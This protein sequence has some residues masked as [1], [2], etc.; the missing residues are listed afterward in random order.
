MPLELIQTAIQHAPKDDLKQK[1]LILSTDDENPPNKTITIEDVYIK[2]YAKE[3]QDARTI[4][5]PI[6]ETNKWTKL[7]K[8]YTIR[9]DLYFSEAINPKP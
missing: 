5:L 7:P 4:L 3:G 1:G 6:Q 2:K 9:I 8:Q